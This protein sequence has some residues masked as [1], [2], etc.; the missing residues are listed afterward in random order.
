[1][2]MADVKNSDKYV[3]KMEQQV[4]QITERNRELEAR[5]A[6]QKDKFAERSKDNVA[7]TAKVVEFQ[8]SV[9]SLDGDKVKQNEI[10]ADLNAQV[11]ELQGFLR[12]KC[13]N[14]SKK[15]ARGKYGR[16]SPSRTDEISITDIS[17]DDPQG[18]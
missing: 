8:E 6:A 3:K 5:F 17:V 18:M 15:N 12:E 1:M 13:D 9:T 4:Q 7:L 11:T 14:C 16:N 10:I 2:S